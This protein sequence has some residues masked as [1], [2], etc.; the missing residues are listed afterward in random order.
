MDIIDIVRSSFVYTIDV[1]D[2]RCMYTIDVDSVC[3][4]YVD[5]CCI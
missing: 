5:L 4:N 3:Y 1:N 2:D